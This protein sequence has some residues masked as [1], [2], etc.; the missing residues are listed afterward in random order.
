MDTGILS[1]KLED[2]NQQ[3]KE[4][5]VDGKDRL[6]F[7][8]FIKWQKIQ[9]NELK[10]ALK[11]KTLKRVKNKKEMPEKRG[12]REMLKKEGKKSLEEVKTKFSSTSGICKE[13]QPERHKQN[14]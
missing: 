6:K 2:I 3:V 14:A 8:F 5:G 12:E 13:L 1:V 11:E 10:H 4:Y 9:G 7:S